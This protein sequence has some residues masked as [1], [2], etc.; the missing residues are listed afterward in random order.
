MKMP[1]I[2]PRRFIFR[3]STARYDGQ[4]STR[5]AQC[6]LLR[7]RAGTHPG[8]A[9]GGPL[10]RAGTAGWRTRQS[11]AQSESSHGAH[12][13]YA[14]LTAVFCYRL[15][16][17]QDRTTIL[18]RPGIFLLSRLMLFSVRIWICVRG[19]SEGALSECT[20]AAP[21][22]HSVAD[23]RHGATVA[24]L[25]LALIGFLFLIEPPMAMWRNI[26][27]GDATGSNGHSVAWA[28]RA[29][30]SVRWRLRSQARTS[31]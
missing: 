3:A 19:I 30:R 11:Y 10:Y 7:G 6:H 18:I 4:R 8:S 2:A 14:A 17:P 12:P 22:G 24:D 23:A 26:I 20:S 29:A 16:R 5:T 13:Q 27:V 15:A 21:S 25:I 9:S 31:H 28:E 1:F